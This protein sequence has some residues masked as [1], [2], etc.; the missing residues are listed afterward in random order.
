MNYIS[1]GYDTIVYASAKILIFQQITTTE[2]SVH[3]G[4]ALFMLV[5]RY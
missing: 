5:Q 2:H 3:R 1:N 4:T